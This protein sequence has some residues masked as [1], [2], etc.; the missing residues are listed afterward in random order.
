MGFYS[1]FM[2][3]YSDLMAFYSDFMGFYSDL[4]SWDFIELLIVIQWDLNGMYP[5][6]LTNIAAI[7]NG[8][9]NGEFSYD[10]MVI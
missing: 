8:H 6:V 2:V 4:I 10:K 9:R 7:E 5:L 3:F 1:G